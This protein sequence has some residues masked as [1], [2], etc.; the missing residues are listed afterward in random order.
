MKLEKETGYSLD[1][2]SISI[3]EW[4]QAKEYS[5]NFYED[6]EGRFKEKWGLFLAFQSMKSDI[7]PAIA[8]ELLKVETGNKFDPDLTGPQTKY[9]RA[10]GMAQFMKNTAPWIADMA[11]I[12]Y[13]EEK[14]FDPYYS[15]TLSVTYLE[16]L[17]QKYDNWDEALTAYNRGIA[18]LETY[19][20]EKGTPKSGYSEEIQEKASL[21]E[22]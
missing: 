21:H 18:G 16:Y 6:S 13:S 11:G 10:Y 2:S 15:M 7:D 17:Y 14:L 8:Y 22:S 12:E 4:K 19:V 1:A 20:L 3:E 9:G 5:K